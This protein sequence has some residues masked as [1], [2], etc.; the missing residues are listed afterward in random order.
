MISKGNDLE[1]SNSR[2][3]FYLELTRNSKARIVIEGTLLIANLV[4]GTH[5]A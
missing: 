3:G 4:P 5:F 2:R 1:G